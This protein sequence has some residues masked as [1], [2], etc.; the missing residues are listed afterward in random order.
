MRAEGLLL[1]QLVL[2]SLTGS[3]CQSV[4]SG[5]RAIVQASQ[6]LSMQVAG[7]L[8]QLVTRVPLQTGP[9]AV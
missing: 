7:I 5:H 9:A 8:L 2:P 6:V 4:E 3:G 1:V